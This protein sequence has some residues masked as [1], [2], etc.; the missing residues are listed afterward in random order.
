MEGPDRTPFVRVWGD[1]YGELGDEVYRAIQ[2]EGWETFLRRHIW[3]RGLVRGGGSPFR[4]EIRSCGE[5][6]QGLTEVLEWTRFEDVSE[7]DPGGKPNIV[8]HEKTQVTGKGIPRTGGYFRPR[9]RLSW[10]STMDPT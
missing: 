1:E 5:V 4:L 3:G 9:D 8:L 2:T 10:S 7:S 6:L